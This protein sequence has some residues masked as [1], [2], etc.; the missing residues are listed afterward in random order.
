MRG[1]HAP[2]DVRLRLG[3]RAGDLERPDG[4]ARRTSASRNNVG[5]TLQEQALWSRVFVTG[6]LRVEHNDSFGTAVVPRGSIAFVGASLVRLPRRHEDQGVG[7]P[8]ASRS[9]RWSSRSAR[10]RSSS[11]TLT[12]TRNARGLSTP[13]SS[14]GLHGRSRARRADLVRQPLPRHHL[15]PDDQ[16]RPSSSQYFNIGSDAGARRRAERRARASAGVLVRGGYTFL[17][18]KIIDSTSSF[19]DVFAAGTV[20]LPPSAKLGVPGPGLD[21][22][23]LTAD[24]TGVFVGRR[25]DSDFSALEPPIAVERR[26]CDLGRP[27]RL[28]HRWA[29]LDHRRHRQPLRRRLHGSARLPGARPSVPHRREG[30]LLAGV[31]APRTAHAVGHR[32]HVRLRTRRPCCV[33]SRSTCPTAGSSASSDPTAPARRRC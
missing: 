27:G 24:V 8:A 13:A 10:P 19:S 4:R 32:R 12:S 29:P 15:D 26:L 1:W 6:G 21:H 14:S 16:L 18:S 25:V 9:R 28:P 23:R 7:R 5:F 20:A 3:R 11:A 33:A 30:A 31:E 2:D 22:D 17:A